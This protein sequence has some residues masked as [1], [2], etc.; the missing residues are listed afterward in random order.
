[1]LS[2][3][4]L[5]KRLLDKFASRTG[6]FRLQHFFLCFRSALNLSHPR[7]LR[8]LFVGGSP[9]KPRLPDDEP[10]LTLRSS[11]LAIKGHFVSS[12]KAL[13]WRTRNAFQCLRCMV[14]RVDCIFC[15][16]WDRSGWRGWGRF[17]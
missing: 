9:T 7:E 6:P 1:M 8:N 4:N 5:L 2:K 16:V 3:F 10:R 13:L 17:L 15:G 12:T 11:L 14:S